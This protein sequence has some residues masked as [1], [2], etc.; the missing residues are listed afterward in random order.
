MIGTDARALLVCGGFRLP[1]GPDAAV[2]ASGV[3]AAADVRGCG[4]VRV[5]RGGGHVVVTAGPWTVALEVDPTARF[6][7]VAAVLTDPPPGGTVVAFTD[8]GLK[9]LAEKVPGL[10]GGD[11]R[12]KAVEVELS[13]PGGVVVSAGGVRVPVPGSKVTGPGAAFATDREYLVRA[14]RTGLRTL[15]VGLP[16]APV[17]ASDGPRRLVWAPLAGP[18]PIRPAPTPLPRTATGVEDPRVSRRRRDEPPPADAEFTTR[19]LPPDVGGELVLGPTASRAD[20][21]GWSVGGLFRSLVERVKAAL[22]VRAAEELEADARADAARRRAADRDAAAA[23]EASGH[24]DAAAELRR[25][26][27]ALV[28]AKARARALG[29]G[30]DAKGRPRRQPK[31]AGGR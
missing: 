8:A 22:A 9:V 30:P 24:P 25:P 21:K 31:D 13:P 20:R 10:P 2:P 29:A 15:A 7:D 23:Y 12:A 1:A 28:G 26:P 27:A 14:A 16:G 11:D 4:P 17:V 3:F 19:V 6:P 18:D 5:G